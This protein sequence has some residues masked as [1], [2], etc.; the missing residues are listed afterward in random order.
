MLEE[1]DAT[2]EASGWLVPCVGF[3]CMSLLGSW[4]CGFIIAHGDVP[5]GSCFTLAEGFS[6]E[7]CLWQ[8]RMPLQIVRAWSGASE[9]C[10]SRGAPPEDIFGRVASAVAAFL[11]RKPRSQA[12]R[13]AF[14]PSCGRRPQLLPMGDQ[15]GEGRI[16]WNCG[17]EASLGITQDFM[18]YSWKVSGGQLK[19]NSML[20]SPFAAPA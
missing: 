7:T 3:V 2:Q 1:A 11:M 20:H 14:A 10:L 8:R 5:H 4:F 16:L 18:R 9:T 13:Q 17:G 19:S 15:E 6:D 12:L